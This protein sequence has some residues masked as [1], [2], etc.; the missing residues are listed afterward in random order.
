MRQEGLLLTCDRCGKQIMLTEK[1]EHDTDGSFTRNITY[2]DEPEDWT[3]HEGKDICDE[4]EKCYSQMMERFYKDV[5][6]E[7]HI[8]EEKKQT[9]DSSMARTLAM[10]YGERKIV[11]DPGIGIW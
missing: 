9:A 11:R 3:K 6:F 1:I 7:K 4:C 5:E 10:N 2:S 8:Y